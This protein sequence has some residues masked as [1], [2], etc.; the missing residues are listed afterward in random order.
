MKKI[1]CTVACIMIFWTGVV[2]QVGIN[3]DNSQPD[4]SSMLDVKS[5]SKGVLL[6]RMT[7]EQRN[8]IPGPAEG[9]MVYCTNCN[10]DGTGVISVFEGG[11]WK[12][13]YHN[14]YPPNTPPAG[15][16]IPQL[17]QITWNWNSVPI[18]LG[19]KWNTV[20]DFNTAMDLGSATSHPETGLTCWTLYTRYV[21]S[22]NACGPSAPGILTQSTSMAPLDSATAATQVPSYYQVTWNWNPSSGAAGYKWNTTNDFSTATD[23]GTSTTHT[24]TGLLCGTYYARYVWAYIP[25]GYA[26]PAVLHQ[27]TLSALASPVAGTLTPIFTGTYGYQIMWRWNTVT[28]A[29]GYKFGSTN[30]FGAA[31]DMGTNTSAWEDH[32]HCDSTY[33]RYLWSY[34]NCGHSSPTTLVQTTFLCSVPPTVTTS[35]PTHVAIDSAR[36]GGAVTDSGNLPVIERGICYATHPNP[37]IYDHKVTCGS[38]IGTFSAKLTNLTDSTTY[39]ARA[40]GKNYDHTGYGNEVTFTTVP[41]FYKGENYQGGKIF[42]ID[43]TKYHGLIAA[44]IDFTAPPDLAPWGCQGTL[45]GTSASTFDGMAN[46]I[47]IVDSCPTPGIAAKMCY[48]MVY[49]GYGDWYLPSIGALSNLYNARIY[50]GVFWGNEYWSSTEAVDPGI[51]NFGSYKAYGITFYDPG[52]TTNGHW[53]PLDKNSGRNVR[54]IRSF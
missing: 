38:G 27:T 42:F 40:Y 51:P 47:S 28:G 14:C 35:A 37:T 34:N 18:S 20:N 24:E 3:S 44:T 1:I 45:V 50:V 11:K 12:T 54:A 15:T 53:D 16:H 26:L 31:T 36:V 43:S 13:I 6:P 29:T 32:L 17:T 22:Y 2:A 10:Q 19:Y 7:V 52:N 48:N 33:T 41:A 21:W 39:Y 9:L 30:N 8:A 4:P 25:C 46:T 23:M 49:N 5:T